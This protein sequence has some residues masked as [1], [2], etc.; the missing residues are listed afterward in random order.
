MKIIFQQKISSTKKIETK[1]EWNQIHIL[2]MESVLGTNCR[3]T[4]I[5]MSDRKFQIE[6]K[7]NVSMSFLLHIC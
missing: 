7:I 2:S 5:H 4:L 6:E 1:D 3:I